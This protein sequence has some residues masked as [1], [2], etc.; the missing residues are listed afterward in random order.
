MSRDTP[1][2]GRRNAHA[3]RGALP[4][5]DSENSPRSWDVEDFSR[6]LTEGIDHTIDVKLRF[7]CWF[8][9]MSSTASLMAV[10][11]PNANTSAMAP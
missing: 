7:A 4:E 8:Y 5:S 1:C 10:A 3:V 2:N 11:I 9:V 6:T